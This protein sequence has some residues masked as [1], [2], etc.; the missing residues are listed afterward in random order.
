[1]QG[2]LLIPTGVLP[3]HEIL[4][5]IMFRVFASPA[6][7]PG[8]AGGGGVAPGGVGGGVVDLYIGKQ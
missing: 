8:K 6:G 1:M 5:Q 7:T 4:P 2:P 3:R